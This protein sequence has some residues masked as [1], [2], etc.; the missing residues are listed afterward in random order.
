MRVLHVVESLDP[1]YG[2]PPAV[3]LNLAA[4][5][6]HHGHR[7]TVL[8]YCLPPRQALVTAA[9]EA[10]GIQHELEVEF[11]PGTNAIERA[12]GLA[13]LRF[14]M[15]TRDQ[16]DVYHVH[17]VWKAIAVW[18]I[19]AARRRCLVVTPHG[20]ISGYGLAQKPLRKRIALSVFWRRAL[21]HADMLQA[22]T[23]IEADALRRVLPN[24][25]IKVIPN[26]INAGEYSE[27]VTRGVFHQRHPEL[28]GRPYVLFLARLD[29]MK[30][31]DLLLSAFGTLT[32]SDP[33]LCLMIAGPDNGL[34]SGV[35]RFIE[36]KR[37]QQRIFVLGPIFGDD[38]RAALAGATCFCQPS[39][40]E[41]F[42]LSIV[43]AM[44][45][46][47]PVVISSECGFDQELVG[48][49]A[50]QIVPLEVPRIAADI[51]GYVRAPQARIEAGMAAR[52]FVLARYTWDRIGPMMLDSYLELLK[53]KAKP[54]EP[55]PH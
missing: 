36:E 55:R 53:G 51:A 12:L 23:E 17:G 16:Y 25:R 18:A 54:G 42:A 33:D 3:V 4:S 6:L 24:P 21:C 28:R 38:K 9:I 47:V 1:Q 34:E 5:Q 41:A 2:G 40:Y 22:L 8:S 44:A 11:L 46:S 43:E 31:L 39:R 15:R 29:R 37:L 7:V 19:R 32:A 45:S 49:G 10:L 27:P 20:M 14:L 26:G 35:R 50:G 48:A 13:A 52:R 30:G